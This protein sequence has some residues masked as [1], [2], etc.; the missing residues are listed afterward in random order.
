VCAREQ[1]LRIGSMPGAH[2]GGPE[3][4]SASLLRDA[5]AGDRVA[6]EQI[7]KRHERGVLLTAFRLLGRWE[8]AQDAGQEVFVRLHKYLHRFDDAREFA[9]WLYRVTVNVCRDI[10]RKRVPQQGLDPDSADPGRG[11]E[12]LARSAEQ[13]RILQA[14]LGRLSERQRAAL[15]LRDLE[16][17][18]TREVA[19][20]LKTSEATVRSHLSA[21]R[22]TIMKLTERFR[23][24][25]Q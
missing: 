17:L 9:P 7:L 2:E 19:R 23:R 15:V 10:G 20:I 16:G 4:D 12:H 18:P 25:P 11:P 21:A 1:A 13:R 24:E 6:F 5:R 22:L 8:D 14:A 3:A